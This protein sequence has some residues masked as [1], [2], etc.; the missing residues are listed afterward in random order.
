MKKHGDRYRRRTAP[1]STRERAEYLVAFT[2]PIEWF[3]DPHGPG[4]HP[5][6]CELRDAI[7]ALVQGMQE[8]AR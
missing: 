1:T 2:A 4:E 3:D 5:R 6:C 8:A 7:V